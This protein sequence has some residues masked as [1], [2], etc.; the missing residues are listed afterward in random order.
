MLHAHTDR[1]VGNV[2]RATAAESYTNIFRR[3]KRK[4]SRWLAHAFENYK[5][6]KPG[7]ISQKLSST[8]HIHFTNRSV[9]MSVGFN[10]P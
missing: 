10:V 7:E 8:L 9:N 3:W 2:G 6:P 1:E 4:F 5:R